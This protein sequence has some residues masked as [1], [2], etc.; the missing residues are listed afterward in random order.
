M[1]NENP[2]YS[3]YAFL[4]NLFCGVGSTNG[5]SR[6][7]GTAIDAVIG[8]DDKLAVL[9]G[10]SADGAFIGTS[11]ASDAIVVNLISHGM[12]L[13]KIFRVSQGYSI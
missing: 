13:L 7:A 8:V 9:F 5:A 10:N 11:A 4:R 2:K 12:Y 1:R 6:S 3:H